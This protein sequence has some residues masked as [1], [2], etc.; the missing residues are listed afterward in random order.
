[1]RKIIEAIAILGGQEAD[2]YLSFVASSHDDEEIRA[3]E[4]AER[5]GTIGYEIV[6]GVSARITRVVHSADAAPDVPDPGDVRRSC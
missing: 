4:W 6:C 3:E 1:M 2:D 5:L